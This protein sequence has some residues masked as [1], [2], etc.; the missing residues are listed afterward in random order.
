M[1]WGDRALE[2]EVIDGR[3]R[4]SLA[5]GDREDDDFVVAVGTR[6]DFKWLETGLDV[7]FSTGVSGTGTIKGSEAVPL[8]QLVERGV[9]KEGPEGFTVTLGAGD[10]LALRVGGQDIEVR[11][12]RGRIARLRI[13]ALAAVALVTVLALLGAWVVSTLAGMS[14]LNLI[15]KNERKK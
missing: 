14:P 12:A 5:L 1:R 11:Q 9:V 13:D 10:S 2:A 4:K 8:G 15:P 7:R 6:L 3:G